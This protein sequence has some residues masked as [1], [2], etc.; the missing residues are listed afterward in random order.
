MT[1]KLTIGFDVAPAVVDLADLSLTFGRTDRITFHPDGVTPESDTD[2]T[3]MLGLVACA[4]ADRWYPHT[5]DRGLVAQFALVHDL[6]EVYAGDTPTLRA[7][8]PGQK[9]DKEAREHAALL[10]IEGQ[11]RMLPWIGQAIRLYEARALPE[12]RFVKALDKLLPK[13]THLLNHAATVRA[14]GVTR[15]EL[16]ARYALQLDEMQA[17]AGEFAELFDLRSLLVDM[18]LSLLTDEPAEVAR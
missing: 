14:E 17:Y 16:A 13:A 1:G 3:V 2:H 8:D 18:V 12:A 10:R 11:F 15:S 9:A 7:L 6:V 5:L 4:L